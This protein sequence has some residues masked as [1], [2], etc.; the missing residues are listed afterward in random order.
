MFRYVE[1]ELEYFLVHPGGPFFRKKDDGYWGIPKG[2]PDD[3]EDLQIA[4]IREFEEE[5]GIKPFGN[6][7]P[8]GSIIQKNNKE[9]FAWAFEG[10]EGSLPKIVSNTF[11]LEWP[12]KS[13]KSTSFPEIDDGRYFFKEEALKKIYE[14][15]A[16]FIYRLENILKTN[17]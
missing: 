17:N 4:A 14:P 2:I 12:Y 6:Y 1:K 16:E 10:K 7:I 5:T 11:Q 9:V 15:Q 13:G 3:G 8:L